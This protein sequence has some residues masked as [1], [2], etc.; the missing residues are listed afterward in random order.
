MYVFWVVATQIYVIFTRILG[1]MIQFDA[2]FHKSGVDLVVYRISWEEVYII[3]FSF[4]IL[5][6]RRQT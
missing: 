4:P 1:E 6:T 3:T 2:K 5:H